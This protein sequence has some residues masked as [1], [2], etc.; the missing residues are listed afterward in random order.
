MLFVASMLTFIA[1]LSSGSLDF[2]CSGGSTC[3]NGLQSYQGDIFLF[4]PLIAVGLITFSLVII[5]SI[6]LL[7]TTFRARRQRYSSRWSS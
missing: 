6:I 2:I 7:G 1:G 5:S 3:V 4:Y